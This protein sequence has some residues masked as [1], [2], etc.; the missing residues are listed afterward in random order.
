MGYKIGL[1]FFCN[2][3]FHVSVIEDF[4]KFLTALQSII[5]IEEKKLESDKPG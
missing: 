2:I 5:E 3:F 1:S 4:T